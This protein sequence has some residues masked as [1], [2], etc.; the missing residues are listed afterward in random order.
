MTRHCY[1]VAK[2]KDVNYFF[3]AYK[4]N[5]D[6][7]VDWSLP[8]EIWLSEQSIKDTH[9]TKFS[10]YILY[11]YFENVCKFGSHICFFFK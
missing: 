6:V 11:M 9:A 10:E 8:T 4:T 1:V 5:L 3:F 2:L 7:F